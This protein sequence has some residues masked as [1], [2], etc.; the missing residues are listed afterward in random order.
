MPKA[1]VRQQMTVVGER[2]WKELNGEPCIDLELV[3]PDKKQICTSRAF[4]E[5]ISEIEG[6]EEAVSSYASICAGKLRKQRSCAQAL[7]VFI[8]TN[9]FRED[10]PQYF[11]NCVVKLPLPTN[12]TPEIVHYALIAL[13][14]IYRKGYFF[15]K[16]GVIIIDIVPDSA[17]QQNMFDN[18]DRE[19]QKKLM[20]VVDRL[21]S[22]FNRNNLTLAVQGGRRKWKL[23]QELLSP[24]Y[25]TRLSDIINIK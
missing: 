6:L 2:T 25:T 4:G 8:H 15:K 18:V 14:N 23:K 24:C 1:W 22:G 12:N 13:R 7:M 20:K 3:T 10:L 11:Q 17:I 5:A 19:R 21:N 16:A 9:N